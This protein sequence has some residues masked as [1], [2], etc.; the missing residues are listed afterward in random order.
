LPPDDSAL[1]FSPPGG[2]FTSDPEKTLISLYQRYVEYYTSRTGYP[3]RN[4]DEVWEVFKKPLE[5]QHVIQF[6]KPKRIIAPDYDY[7]FVRARKN[8]AWHTYEP[9]SFDL[10]EATSIV[11]KANTWVGRITSLAQSE[12]KFKPHFLL[13]EP[14][15]TKLH[16]AFTKAQ[17]LLHKMPCEHEFVQE[18][19]AEDLAKHLKAEVEKYGR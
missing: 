4:D 5:E 15:E 10:M 18:T 12:E 16:V 8:E 1:Q 7:E 14:R 19:D 13:G 9:V 3:S 17:N 6:L 2:G 11:D